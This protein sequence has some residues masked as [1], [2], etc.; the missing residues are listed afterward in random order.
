MA[1]QEPNSPSESGTKIFKKG[2]DFGEYWDI[3]Y[4]FGSGLMFLWFYGF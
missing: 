1:N 4:F 2:L 3:F